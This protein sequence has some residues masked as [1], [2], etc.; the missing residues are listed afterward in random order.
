MRNAVAYKARAAV[1]LLVGSS[2]GMLLYCLYKLYPAVA[3]GAFHSASGQHLTYQTEPEGF[4]VVF[5]A[6]GVIAIGSAGYCAWFL[7]IIRGWWL[8]RRG[9]EPS[10][11][12]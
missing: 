11:R 5:V 7:S 2:G 3:Q 10:Q 6:Y 4:I 9:N 1:V 8:R 12:D